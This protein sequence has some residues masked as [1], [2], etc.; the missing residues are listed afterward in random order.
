MR[1]ASKRARAGCVPG[2]LASI[3]DET[4]GEF[5]GPYLSASY[6]ASSPIQLA[7][8]VEICDGTS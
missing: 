2:L 4:G 3:C 8:S 6:A 5:S 7:S 1:P